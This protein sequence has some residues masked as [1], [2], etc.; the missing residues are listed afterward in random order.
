VF[1]QIHQHSRL[2]FA[3]QGALE[4]F[5]DRAALLLDATG[6]IHAAMPAAAALFQW[7]V[8]DLAGIPFGIV[9]LTQPE[10]RVDLVNPG[11]RRRTVV[12]RSVASGASRD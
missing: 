7:R 4:R 12:A 10:I 11:G 6:T 9:P 8:S 3:A 1:E 5:A 2:N